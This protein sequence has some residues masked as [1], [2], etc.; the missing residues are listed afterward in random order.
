M[1]RFPPL[2]AEAFI[3]GSIRAIGTWGIRPEEMAELMQQ[4][5]HRRMERSLAQISPG[6]RFARSQHVRWHVSRIPQ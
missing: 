2:E 3:E 6:K 5:E 4:C 1:V